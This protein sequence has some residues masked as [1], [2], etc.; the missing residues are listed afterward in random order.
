MWSLHTSLYL[1]KYIH[2][3]YLITY[4]TSYLATYTYIH[5]GR[6]RAALRGGRVQPGDAH[7]VAG[8]AVRRALRPR[9]P[10]GLNCSQAAVA[11]LLPQ[12]A[13]P[14]AADR[15]GEGVLLAGGQ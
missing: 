8:A 9:Q 13:L 7:P 4:G 3:G 2:T 12:R 11:A 6:R 1:V 14:E 5:T 10:A 15:A